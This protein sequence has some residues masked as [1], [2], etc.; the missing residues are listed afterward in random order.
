MERSTSKDT[1]ERRLSDSELESVNGGILYLAG[2]AALVV[3]GASAA[4]EAYLNYQ[5]KWYATR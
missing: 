4:G 1:T 2:V 5:T 3:A